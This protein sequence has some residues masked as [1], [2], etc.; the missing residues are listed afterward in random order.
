MKTKQ[1]NL[2]PIWHTSILNDW[3]FLNMQDKGIK[4][5]LKKS[6]ISLRAFRFLNEIFLTDFS[7]LLN[8]RKNIL[9]ILEVGALSNE[10]KK[11]AKNWKSSITIHTNTKSSPKSVKKQKQKTQNVNKW[12]ISIW[13]VVQP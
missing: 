1:R 2:M 11:Y 5:F 10:R 8:L 13:K 7:T 9:T 4:F 6:R 12:P 3:L